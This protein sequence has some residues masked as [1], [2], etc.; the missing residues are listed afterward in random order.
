MKEEDTILQKVGKEKAFRTPDGY[1]ENL[2]SHIMSQLPEKEFKMPLEKKVGKWRRL[3]PVLY[4]AAAVVIVLLAFRV[5]FSTQ[6]D[7]QDQ[8]SLKESPD[9]EIGSDRYVSTAMDNSMLD[10]YSLYVYL[11]DNE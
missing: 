9:T 1:L 2:T 5:F 4:G 8:I 3:R 7:V 10:D 11:T 6:E